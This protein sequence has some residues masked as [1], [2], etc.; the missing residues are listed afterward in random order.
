M[1]PNKIRVGVD[2]RPLLKEGTGV[3][4]Y[5][6][7][8]FE[9]FSACDDLEFVLF[10]SSFKDRLI[11]YKN[12]S[13]L[14]A[15][16]IDLKIPVSILNFLWNNLGFPQIENLV[17]K[18][19]IFHS[20]HSFYIPVRCRKEIITIHDLFHLKE[21]ELC[22]IKN[23]SQNRDIIKKAAQKADLIIVPS[24]FTK[25]DAIEI[26][27]IPEEKIF[28]I[29]Y[30]PTIKPI[31]RKV[32]PEHDSKLI[33]T[34]GT[35]EHRKNLLLLLD[36]FEIVRKQIAK[37][38]LVIVGK[39]GFGAETIKQR[40]LEL[41][42]VRKDI[43]FTGYLDED[44]LRKQYEIADVF[45][46][47]SLEEG[48]GFPPLDAMNIDI[49]VVSSRAGS[50]FEILGDAPYYVDHES[51]ESIANGILKILNDQ[52][53]RNSLIAQGMQVASRYTWENTA[54]ETYKL[55]ISLFNKK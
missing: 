11:L 54:K 50:L 10:S 20:P 41:A 38:K 40:G 48:F 23:P 8:L 25:R 55:Y 43:I 53:L 18:I 29:N 37:A 35:I 47:P 5:T 14:N 49:P 42:K 32:S 36:A 16:I 24:F 31:D 27:K 2:V 51:P 45:V 13:G 26:L 34:V 33:L 1:R 4:Y 6:K 9:A 46:F 44:A 30:A 21:P 22:G 28:V 19:D 52:Y 3:G 12:F 7:N 15:K 39:D 17:G